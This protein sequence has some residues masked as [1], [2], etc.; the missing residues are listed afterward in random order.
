MLDTPI[1]R[2]RLVWDVEHGLP[3]VWMGLVALESWMTHQRIQTA[4]HG[5][6]DMVFLPH[7]ALEHGGTVHIR[8]YIAQR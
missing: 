4:Y 6:V 7:S 3:Y 8:Q 1:L 2:D 5:I